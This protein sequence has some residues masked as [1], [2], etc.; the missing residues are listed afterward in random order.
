MRQV[1][2][3]TPMDRTGYAAAAAAAAKQKTAVQE[4]LEELLNKVDD[5]IPNAKWVICLDYTVIMVGSS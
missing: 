5:N 4:D 3:N 1:P 2:Q